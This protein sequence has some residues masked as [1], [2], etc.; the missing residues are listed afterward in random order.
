MQAAIKK[1]NV[2]VQNAVLN[3]IFHKAEAE[4]RATEEMFTLLGWGDLPGEFKM[5]IEED[6]K[7][8]ID[9]LRGQ[10][11]T[12]SE[13]VQRRRESVDFWVN[14]YLDGICDETTA[15]DSLRIKKL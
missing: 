14:S 10:Y 11:C 7:G 9:E 2:S 15:I 3:S 13:W 1:S 12:N 6:V 4:Y 5:V 8:Y